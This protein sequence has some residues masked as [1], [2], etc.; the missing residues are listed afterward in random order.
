VER[1]G[2]KRKR[3]RGMERGKLRSGEKEI[4][5]RRG[6]NEV[7]RREESAVKGKG[8]RVSGRKEEKGR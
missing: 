2:E 7:N 3:G 4:S 6:E 8:E 1:L 5:T